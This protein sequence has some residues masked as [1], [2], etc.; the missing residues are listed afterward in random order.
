MQTFDV[1]VAGLGA[2]GSAALYQLA[3]CRVKTLGIDR[4]HPPH[5]FGSTHGETRLTRSA[6]G[7]G[8]EFVPLVL[9]SNEIWTEIER[10]TGR[11]L[12]KKTGGLIFTSGVGGSVLHGKDILNETIRIAEKF[13]IRHEVLGTAGLR[14]RFPDL[15]AGE[16]ARGYYEHEAGYLLPEACVR[17]NIEESVR[18]GAEVRTGEAVLSI[19]PGTDTV[20]VTTDKDSYECC[21]VV[22]A[23]GAW[24]NK[25]IPG[26]APP[27]RFRIFRQTMIWFETEADYSEAHFPVYIMAGENEHSSYYGFPSITGSR[28]IKI[29]YE[30]FAEEADPDYVDREVSEDQIRTAY[31]MVS[32]NFRIGRTAA[33]ARTCLYTVTRD[34]GFVI[35]FLPGNRNVIVVS[36]CSGHGFKHSAGVGLLAKQLATDETPFTD[37]ASFRFPVS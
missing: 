37:T 31:E 7:E 3:R 26:G 5:E 14:E 29:G 33:D 30:Q 22:L 9:K 27:G 8:E 12:L 13:S 24:V 21:R 32:R 16:S 35:D 19:D 25:L 23:A 11:E 17:T 10:T 2:M 4:F 20:N 18:L 6:V 34:F 15:D 1:I 36:P 28:T